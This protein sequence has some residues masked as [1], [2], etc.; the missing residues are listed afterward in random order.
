MKIRTKKR[1]YEQV[2]AMKR[3]K[4]RKPL[5][6]NMLLSFV[7]RVLSI[8]DLFPT[9]FTFQKHGMDRIDPKE[10]VLIL[11]NH[12]SFIDLKIASRIFF[13]KRSKCCGDLPG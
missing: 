8:F 9:K 13:P 10:P 3:P 4:H 11:M 2:V 7:I 6:P 5:R 1:T 12:S